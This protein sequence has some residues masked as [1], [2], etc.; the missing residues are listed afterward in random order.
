MKKYISLT[1]CLLTVVSLLAQTNVGNT[2]SQQNQTLFGNPSHIG[3]YVG[4]DFA[5]T[6]FDNRDV[7]LMGLSSGVVLNHS[8]TLG[9]AGYGIM[10]SNN[11]RYSG[12][13]EAGDLYLYGGY[14]GMKLEYRLFPSSAVNV[15]LPLLVGGGG[16]V[17]SRS[18]WANN[19]YEYEDSVYAS[20]GFFVVEPGVMVGLNLL[21]FMRLDLGVTYR[22]VPNLDLPK[23]NSGLINGFNAVASL[24]FGNL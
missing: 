21:S 24:R 18:N 3:W 7:F 23:T 12:I 17:Y 16:L 14:G 5:F 10:N 4:P 22:Y 1:L 20:D 15:N 19:D 2:K 11:L 6:Q 13:S 8:F 9:L